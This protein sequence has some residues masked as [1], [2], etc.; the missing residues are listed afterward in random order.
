MK[1]FFAA[2]IRIAEIEVISTK[3]WK[4]Y[5]RIYNNIG[6]YT[7]SDLLVGDIIYLDAISYGFGVLRYKV[8]EICEETTSFRNY[9]AIIE[10]D[11]DTLEYPEVEPIMG[12]SG[13]ISNKGYLNVANLPEAIESGLD[14]NFLVKVENMEMNRLADYL[15]DDKQAKIVISPIKPDLLQDS[16][17]W[18]KD[19]GTYVEI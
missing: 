7:I 8:S 17:L 12:V 4:I 18:I 5:G 6:S 19:N 15:N 13:F 1:N 14:N 16:Q 2:K 9:V 11:M 3:K 10:W